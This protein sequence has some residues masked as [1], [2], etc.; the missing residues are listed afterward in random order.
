M[1]KSLA[2]W[3]YLGS[4]SGD[5]DSSNPFVSFGGA[6]DVGS[7]FALNYN[8]TGPSLITCSDDLYTGEGDYWSLDTWYHMVGTYDESGTMTLYVDG[9]SI[10][11]TTAS[12]DTSAS[13]DHIGVGVDTWWSSTYHWLCDG[14]VDEVKVYDY[15]LTD[16][17]VEV[18]YGLEDAGDGPDLICSIDTE[19]TDADGDDITYTIE[20]DVDGVAYTDAT[21]TYYTGDTVPYGDYSSGETWTCTVT[22]N[23]G[24]EDGDSASAEYEVV[25]CIEDNG[26][27]EE[28]P[29]TD[30]LQILED[31]YSSGDGT[32]W[33]DPDGSGAFEVECDM[34]VDGGGWTLLIPEYLTA[35]SAESRQY[36]YTDGTAWYEGPITTA[37]WD[38]T[39]YQ[40]ASGDYSY[41]SSGSTA[42]G[43]FSCTE[44]IG[45]NWGVG[46]SN[47]GSGAT[48][49]SP[50]PGTACGSFTYDEGAATSC[51]CQDSPDVFA[52]GTCAPNIYIY[53]R[54]GS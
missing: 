32:Y 49:V 4:K 44:T 9:S 11:T 39:S 36:F 17:E 25:G 35:L 54:R 37:V 6:C 16:A 50:G 42:T 30:C 53:E 23:D 46:C 15:A 41:A 20:W 47:G 51:V 22:P 8:S 52:A 43:S 13:Y 24:Y 48:K 40:S 29:G 1:P 27:T 7:G 28:C 38:W 5:G 18:L 19:S 34:T 12:L 31:G 33:I 10:G 2:A 21:T 3:V 14:L 45:A 26:E